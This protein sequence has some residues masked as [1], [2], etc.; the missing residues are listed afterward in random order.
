[1]CVYIYIYIN[2][3]RNSGIPNALLL[4]LPC[5]AKLCVATVQPVVIEAGTRGAAGTPWCMLEEHNHSM[6]VNDVCNPW[7]NHERE[8]AKL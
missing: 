3:P 8:I 7:I 1:M 4:T 5:L 6:I 2:L